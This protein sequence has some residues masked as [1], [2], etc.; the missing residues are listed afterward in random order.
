MSGYQSELNGLQHIKIF[1]VIDQGTL[2][3]ANCN[4]SYNGM[5]MI[6][7][8]YAGL[9]HQVD[10]IRLPVYI[11]HSDG[12]FLYKTD[13]LHASMSHNLR[14]PVQIVKH[15]KNGYFIYGSAS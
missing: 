8:F 9:E 7:V 1:I 3:P 14:A 13:L 6:S 12:T 5:L 11:Y 10:V 2:M 15:V 4:G